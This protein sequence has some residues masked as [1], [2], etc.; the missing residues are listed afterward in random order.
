[1]KNHIFLTLKNFKAIT[2][3][4]KK[5]HAEFQMW[6]RIFFFFFFDFVQ[7]FLLF[8]IGFVFKINYFEY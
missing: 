5:H 4:G 8:F 7:K 3:F 6:Y 1:M 2:I